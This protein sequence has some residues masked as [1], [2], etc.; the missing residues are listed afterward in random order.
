M[1]SHPGETADI[2]LLRLSSEI[3]HHLHLQRSLTFSSVFRAAE[4][5]TGEAS[6]VQDSEEDDL[7]GDREWVESVDLSIT[8]AR[9]TG[10]LGRLSGVLERLT[11]VPD[12]LGGVWSCLV[13][14]VCS[15]GLD[16]VSGAA[17]PESILRC[18]RVHIDIKST[19]VAW[20]MLL[21]NIRLLTSETME[22]S[23][24]VT[25][26]VPA[27]VPRPADPSPLAESSPAESCGCAESS[28]AAW[29]PSRR[30]GRDGLPVNSRFII[31]KWILH[32]STL[33]K[34]KK[35]A[36]WN[37]LGRK[38]NS[39]IIPPIRTRSPNCQPGWDGPLTTTWRTRPVATTADRSLR[40]KTYLTASLR[41]SLHNTS[42]LQWATTW[43]NSFPP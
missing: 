35:E 13:V 40:N 38:T 3:R 23:C 9:L 37:A 4:K 17:I 22:V 20:F 30:T 34:T 39:V 21:G 7:M 29:Q 33:S 24:L 5:L 6:L 10:V 18:M 32:L 11:G 14:G 42:Q 28:P 26:V 43:G 8:L 15:T 27:G 36:T 12:L 41:R 1:T 31:N 16:W 2:V 25:G 19:K